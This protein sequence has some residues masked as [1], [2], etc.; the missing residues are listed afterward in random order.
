M[1][2]R[3]ARHRHLAS[4]TGGLLRLF[5]A[6]HTGVLGEIPRAGKRTEYL[7]THSLYT[8]DQEGGR[9]MGR[10]DGTEG[11][12]RDNDAFEPTANT[13]NLEVRWG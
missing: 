12:P 7:L 11:A 1:L 5:G 9:G 10:D 2:I 8:D 13:N 3:I 4:R 6:I